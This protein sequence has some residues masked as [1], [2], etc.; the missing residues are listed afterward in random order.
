[1]TLALRGRGGMAVAMLLAAAMLWVGWIGYVESDD[2]LYLS[3]ARGWLAHAPY[4]GVSH[5]ELRHAIVLPMALGIR[6]FGLSEATL[7]GVFTLY[8]FVVLAV[9]QSFARRLGGSGAAAWSIVIAATLP[10][11]VAGATF[12]TTD[13]PEAAWILLSLWCHLR[14][15]DRD[16]PGWHVVAGLCAGVALVTRETSVVLVGLYG[17]MFLAGVG[18]GRGRYLLV[19]LGA[20]IVV[21]C[22]TLYLWVMSGDPM[23]RLEI[24]RKGV[25]GDGPQMA[26]S[27]ATA[28]GVDRF[29]AIAAPDLLRPLVVTFANQ[30]YGLYFWCALPAAWLVSRR[31]AGAGR[32]LAIMLA[33]LAVAWF[34]VLGYLLSDKLWIINRY[35]MLSAFALAPVLAAWLAGGGRGRTLVSLS[36]V[37]VNVVLI[38]ASDRDPLFVE[39][40]LVD[41]VITAGA[42]V[43][44]DS[45]TMRTATFLLAVRGLEGR[46]AALPPAPGSYYFLNPRPRRAGAL[47]PATPGA[48]WVV[49][50][51]YVRP[52][53]GLARIPGIDRLAQVL[54]AGLRDKL[55]P[56][57]IEAVLY[58]VP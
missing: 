25:A 41:A 50:Q 4:L 58:R 53:F 38:L 1:M 18:G 57:P 9:V 6:L 12:A 39:R 27:F 31:P 2:L 5:W 22:D 11:V 49:Q 51:R 21:G 32:R 15:S 42:P 44:T 13:V 55:V 48:N 20:G 46:A 8:A 40:R 26:A 23:Y 28:A 56:P 30:G 19:A 29:G 34:I 37:A 45:A 7:I 54:P 47:R 16:R 10:V 14:A 35:M 3:G 43:R 33:G 24:A 17:L 36:L 52:P